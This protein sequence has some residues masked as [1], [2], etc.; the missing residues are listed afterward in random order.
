MTRKYRLTPLW[1]VI[2]AVF[3]FVLP[4]KPTCAQTTPV[5][6][7]PDS[8]TPASPAAATPAKAPTAS[9]IQI[10]PA[11]ADDSAKP[12]PNRA[13]AYYHMALASGYEDQAVSEGRPE[14][15]TRAIEEYKLALNADPTSPQLNLMLEQY[16]TNQ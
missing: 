12:I 1:L 2:A 3:A 8:A 13:Q 14:L 16:V 10:A 15:V 5:Q 4:A 6:K 11:K 9:P 7:G